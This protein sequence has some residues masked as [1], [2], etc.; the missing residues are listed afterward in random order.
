MVGLK[1]CGRVINYKNSKILV[2]N[3]FKAI[4]G[5]WWMPWVWEAM[6]DVVSCDKPG[7]T[8]H[9]YYIPGFPNG[10]THYTEGIVLERE[11]T[12][13]TETSK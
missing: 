10:S 8:A 7:E 9:K 6:K 13:W 2:S 3:F 11:P 1:K 5:A 12:S 4:K